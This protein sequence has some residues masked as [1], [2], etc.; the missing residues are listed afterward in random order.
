MSAACL[1]YTGGKELSRKSCV[2]RTC[3]NF[4]QTAELNLNISTLKTDIKKGSER[5]YII[6]LIF[7]TT[8]KLFVILI[9]CHRILTS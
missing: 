1:E 8:L 5:Y 7:F 6:F 2:E 4:R 3:R 9:Q